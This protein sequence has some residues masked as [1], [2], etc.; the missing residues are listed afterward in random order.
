MLPPTYRYAM[1]TNILIIED[2]EET[3]RFLAKG[4]REAGH[5]VDEAG[6][7]ED[8]LHHAREGSHDVAIIDRMLPRL[9]GLSIVR[10]LRTCVRVSMRMAKVRCNP[11]SGKR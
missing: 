7:G 11:A 9:D 1:S 2:D 5:V 6:D 4:L 3:R 8:G 10:T